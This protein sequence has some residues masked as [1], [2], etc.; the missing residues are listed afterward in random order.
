M[1]LFVSSFD[2]CQ[3][4]S[5]TLV[6]SG[7]RGDRGAGSQHGEVFVFKVTVEVEVW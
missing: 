5:E 6:R 4:T 7:G 3:A 2:V 1:M